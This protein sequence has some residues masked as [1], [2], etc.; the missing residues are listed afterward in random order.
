ALVDFDVR[1]AMDGEPL[2]EAEWR[3]LQKAQGGLVLVRGRWVE[4][5]REK[6]E[7]VLRHWEA[8]SE[9][10]LS[11]REAMRLLAGAPEAGPPPPD[12]AEGS[13]VSAGPPPP[14]ALPA[15]GPAEGPVDV[16]RLPGEIRP[17][18]ATGA[19]RSPLRAAPA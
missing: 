12:V 1:L 14:H 13:K 18:P 5:D 17:R 11:L 10:E 2:S 4:L 3:N 15:R 16:R 6:L 9:G 8:A 7:S 19:P